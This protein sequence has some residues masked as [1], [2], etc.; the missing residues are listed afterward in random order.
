MGRLM[1]RVWSDLLDVVVILGAI[2][3]AGVTIFKV[4]LA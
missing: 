4:W 1:D 2:T 3:L